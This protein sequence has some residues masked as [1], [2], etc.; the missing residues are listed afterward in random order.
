M[1]SKNAPIPHAATGG[2]SRGLMLLLASTGFCAGGV[3][4][5]HSPVLGAMAQEFGVGPSVIGW[6][7]T[8]TYAGYFTG[9]IFIVPIGD[10]VDKRR[11]ML[12]QL[13]VLIVANVVL[14][15]AS[16]LGVMMAGSFV[17]G[18]CVCLTQNLVPIAVGASHPDERGKVVGTVLMAM[19]LGFLFNR[20]ASGLI[21]AYFGWRWSFVF[22]VLMLTPLALALLLRLPSVAPTT[23]I[24]YGSLLRSVWTLYRANRGLRLTSATQFFLA[25]GYGGFWATLAPMLLLLHG[26]GPAEAGMMA[27]PGAAGVFISRPAGRWMDRSGARP[28]VLTSILVFIASLAI[29]GFSAWWIGAV[30]VGAAVMDC[31]LRG[32]IVANQTLVA[33][34]DADA[35]NR[36][37]T[38]FGAHNWGGNTMGAFLASMALA[39]SG[40]TA[41]CVIFFG[42]ALLALAL[43]WRLASTTRVRR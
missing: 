8:L 16:S 35:R 41:V 3:M 4:H 20:L 25:I 1:S 40:W 19:F 39:Y 42:G 23:R 33:G 10:R 11:L 32:A 15:T 28:V 12:A 13:G 21:G 38:I 14:A 6:V 27:I 37:N 31:G 18:A 34:V 30:I 22:G 43:Q 17:L 9:L 36:S 2:L 7:A 24:G 29:L 5:V 26:M